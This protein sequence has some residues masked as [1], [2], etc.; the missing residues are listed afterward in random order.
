MEVSYDILQFAQ[1]GDDII[2]GKDEAGWSGAIG[3]KDGNGSGFAPGL[4]IKMKVTHHQRLLNL[5]THFPC[6]Q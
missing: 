5:D 6:R 4:D 2:G 3:K 1:M